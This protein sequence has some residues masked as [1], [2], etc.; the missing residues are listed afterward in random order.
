VS[1]VPGELLAALV[2]TAVRAARVK[3]INGKWFSLHHGTRALVTKKVAVP[4]NKDCEFTT[5][6]GNDAGTF[7]F[8]D[9]SGVKND[10]S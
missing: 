10:S 9:P 4:E 7:S 6:G 2:T 8:I 1:A 3:N 5:M